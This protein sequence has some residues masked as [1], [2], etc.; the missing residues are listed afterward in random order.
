[1]LDNKIKIIYVAGWGRSGSSILSNVLGQL[2]GVFSAG[3]MRYIGERGI[4]SNRLCGCGSHF[5]DCE[6]WGKV[7]LEAFGAGWEDLDKYRSLSNVLVGG[8]SVFYFMVPFGKFRFLGRYREYIGLLGEIYRA[9]GKVSG[10]NVIVDTSKLPVF[11]YLL[12]FVPGVDLYTV[13]LVR[14]PRAV[15]FSWQRKKILE[16][17][18]GGIFIDRH[19]IVKSG[20]QW[21]LMNFL[22][23]RLLN[24]KGRYLRIRYEDLINSP[25]DQLRPV[26]DLVGIDAEKLPIENHNEIKMGVHHTVSGN[27]SRFKTGKIKLRLDD[28]WR[29]KMDKWRKFIVTAITF[30]LA[31]RYGYLKK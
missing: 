16:N 26:M 25:A 22:T 1:M 4:K 14:D 15:A 30:P 27:P 3:E 11:G 23:E 6:F 24:V 12:R 5:N 31:F 20:A 8:G 7:F 28:E 19:N 13:H 9:I 17:V 18:D 2:K 10:N 21:G 29:Y